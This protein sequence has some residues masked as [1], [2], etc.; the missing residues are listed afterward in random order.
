[1]E[2]RGEEKTN[3]FAS[4][5]VEGEVDVMISCDVVRLSRLGISMEEKVY[6][7]SFL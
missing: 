6:A 3:P 4:G 2:G 1:M 5:V 7:A